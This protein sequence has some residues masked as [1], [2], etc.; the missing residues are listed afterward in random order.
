MFSFLNPYVI[1]GAARAAPVIVRASILGYR[2]R[3]T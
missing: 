2:D 1:G 3:N